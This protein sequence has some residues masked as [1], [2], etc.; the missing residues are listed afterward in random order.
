MKIAIVFDGLG[1][2][3]IEKV[4]CNYLNIFNEL[5]HQLTVYNLTPAQDELEKLVPKE[6]VIKP[7]KLRRFECPDRYSVLSKYYW[8][9]KFAYP[10]IWLILKLWLSLKKICF[11]DK[12]SYDLIISFSCHVNDLTFVNENF[13]KSKHKLVWLHGSLIEY[14]VCN[15]S[16]FK[17]FKQIKN[18]CTISDIMQ[19]SILNQLVRLQD[20]NI[21]KIYNPVFFSTKGTKE[22][23]KD[24]YGDYILSVGRFAYPKDYIT[25]INAFEML[26]QKYDKPL[27]FLIVGDGEDLNKDKI[28]ALSKN[29][30]SDDIIFVG[31]T[32]EVEKYYQSAKIFLHSSLFEGLPTVILEAMSYNIPVVST[33]SMPGVQEILQDGKYGLLS[34]IH[35]SNSLSENLFKLLTDET[36]YNHYVQQS[37]IR[38]ESFSKDVIKNQLVE[39]IANLQ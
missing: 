21:T 39:I 13:L 1:F 38:A 32:T 8:W 3:G 17:I 24:V 33:K 28:Y 14:L 35:D 2:G 34:P 29:K 11:I 22:N 10:I 18:C 6:I 37:R 27:K 9:G 4:G 26:K 19:D 31:A 20:I 5:G 16:Y 15:D 7:Y 30:V 36:K 23:L 25:S 12:T